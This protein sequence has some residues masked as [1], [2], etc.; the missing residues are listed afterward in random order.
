LFYLFGLLSFVWVL[1]FCFSCF[2]FAPFL[3]ALNNKYLS[4]S[5]RVYSQWVKHWQIQTRRCGA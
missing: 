5:N 3:Q 2:C 1:L 4:F